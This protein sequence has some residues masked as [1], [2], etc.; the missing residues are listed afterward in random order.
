MVSFL[1]KLVSTHP[2]ATAG[3]VHWFRDTKG[4]FCPN[5]RT[6]STITGV[7][8]VKIEPNVRLKLKP[9]SL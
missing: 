6:A 1:Y 5:Q 9:T 8:L 7:L 2:I 4:W 3:A